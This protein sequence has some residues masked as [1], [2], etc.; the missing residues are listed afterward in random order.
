MV[1]QAGWGGSYRDRVGHAGMGWGGSYK[2]GVG[3]IR[4][5]RVGITGY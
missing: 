4:V 3:H 5:G 1:G 2:D